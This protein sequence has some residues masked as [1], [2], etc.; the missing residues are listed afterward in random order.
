MGPTDE[1]TFG[2]FH[3]SPARG[4]R[5]RVAHLLRE[6][7]GAVQATEAHP[8]GF[9]TDVIG[10]SVDRRPDGVWVELEMIAGANPS[11]YVTVVRAIATALAAA[12]LDHELQGPDWLEEA[13]NRARY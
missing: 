5:D 13:I 3:V 2:E 1:T 10:L 6:A 11:D 7:V 8:S 12:R 9:S 4:S